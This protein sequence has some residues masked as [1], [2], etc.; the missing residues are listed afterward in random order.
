MNQKTEEFSKFNHGFIFDAQG[1]SVKSKTSAQDKAQP[2]EEETISEDH[3][4]QGLTQ[5]NFDGQLQGRRAGF[6]EAYALGWKQGKETAQSQFQQHIS[7]AC[8][9]ALDA[10]VKFINSHQNET[11]SQQQEIRKIGAYVALNVARKL[12]RKALSEMP[13]Q[14]IIDMVEHIITKIKPEKKLLLKVN[15]KIIDT[16]KPYADKIAENNSFHGTLEIQGDEAIDLHD[17]HITWANSGAIYNL[18]DIESEIETLVNQSF[19]IDSSPLTMLDTEET[20]AHAQDSIRSHLNYTGQDAIPAPE[21]NI[22]PPKE[23]PL[24]KELRN[25]DMTPFDADRYP[26][27]SAPPAEAP[28]EEHTDHKENLDH[29]D[30]SKLNYNNKKNIASLVIE[31]INKQQ[32]KTKKLDFQSIQNSFF[33]SSDNT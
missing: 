6:E 7:D 31:D 23:V 25:I 33:G 8:T 12:A 16:L 14:H 24:P 29:Q 22:K 32:S 4:Y 15:P 26:V 30:S 20:P 1:N 2:V 5:A 9:K 27:L 13:D 11:A 10:I 3:F 28:L 21:L 19:Q 18:S 17:A